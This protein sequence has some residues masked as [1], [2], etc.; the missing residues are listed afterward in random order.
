MRSRS[1][2]GSSASIFASW[3]KW[4]TKVWKTQARYR[5]QIDI[6]FENQNDAL[7]SNV[8]RMPVGSRG[9]KTVAPDAARGR[10]LRRILKMM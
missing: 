7:R 6:R 3:A 4:T 5:R 10:Y 9:G 8:H 2:C 1:T